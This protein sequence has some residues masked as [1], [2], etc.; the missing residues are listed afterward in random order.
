MEQEQKQISGFWQPVADALDR[1]EVPPVFV[2]PAGDICLDNGSNGPALPRALRD[3][4]PAE[5]VEEA[6]RVREQR[7]A[8]ARERS[9][10][11]AERFQAERQELLAA[12][13]QEHCHLIAGENSEVVASGTLDHC[14]TQLHR[15]T[16][17]PR[18]PH[19]GR[20]CWVIVANRRDTGEQVEVESGQFGRDSYL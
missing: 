16:R 18:D 12:I 1:G 17:Q 11:F 4:L 2:N 9:R 19:S 3:R 7:E 5:I 14:R 20:G 10:Q 6:Q 15:V 13:D 8:E